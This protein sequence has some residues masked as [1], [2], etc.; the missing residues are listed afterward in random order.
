MADK[1]IERLFDGRKPEE[2]PRKIKEADAAGLRF[3]YNGKPCHRGH[4]AAREVKSRACVICRLEASLKWEAENKPQRVILRKGRRE[5]KRDEICEKQRAWYTENAEYMREYQRNY[6]ADDPE[7]HKKYIKR[8]REKHPERA[9][10]SAQKW[11]AKNP[12]RV[13]ANKNAARHRRRARLKGGGGSHTATEA[14]NLRLYQKDRCAHP[15]CRKNLKGG[16]EKDH[17]I[18]VSRGG[19]DNIENIQWLCKKC[20]REKR[21]KDPIVFAQEHGFLL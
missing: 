13:R 16:G 7:R 11:Q 5:K 20:N 10:I 19:S 6:R 17:K 4:I 8:H 15:W 14:A 18:P 1:E 9:T 3:Y 12:S 2:L 21:A